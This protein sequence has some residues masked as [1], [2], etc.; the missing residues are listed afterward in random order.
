MS[1]R[2]E[3]RDEPIRLLVVARHPFTVDDLGLADL[4]EVRD[5]QSDPSSRRPDDGDR[6]DPTDSG[7][8]RHRVR[9]RARIT[10]IG[11]AL[12][13]GPNIKVIALTPDRAPHE[14]VALRYEPARRGSST[15]TQTR[16]ASPLRF[17]PPTGA[18]SI[19]A[20]LISKGL[21]PDEGST[22]GTKAA[23][24]AISSMADRNFKSARALIK[25][26]DG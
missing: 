3:R 19:S 4:P 5:G 7:D 8:D 12:A 17:G 21:I 6:R 13:Q 1:S 23:L 18:R 22:I 15:S 11:E 20:N 26:M 9:R 16:M 24:D 25:K 14:D 10:A 2:S